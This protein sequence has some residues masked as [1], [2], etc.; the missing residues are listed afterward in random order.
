MPNASAQLTASEIEAYRRDGYVVPG[1][2][3]PDDRLADLRDAVD[4]LVRDNADIPPESLICPHIPRSPAARALADRFLAI[5]LM[6][7]ILDLVEAAIGPDIILW[8]S[9]VFCKP[10]GNGREV[11]WHQDGH[12]WPI[13]PL[14]TCSAWL[15]VDDVTAENGCMRFIPGSHRAKALFRHVASDRRDLALNQVLDPDAFDEGKAHDNVLAAGQLSLHDIH[16]IHGS[17]ANR[18]GRRRAG[19]VVRYMPSDSLFDRGLG[20]DGGTNTVTFNLSQRPIWLARGRDLCGRNDFD[21]GHGESYHLASLLSD[22]I[23][24]GP[25]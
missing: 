16:L 9:Q 11:P 6:P 23:R 19:F 12:F 13:R 14:A 7:E 4:T 10:A 2:R 8:G 17:R 24:P 18:S 22:E 25:G 1:W 15:A 21:T 20:M 5:A 3:L